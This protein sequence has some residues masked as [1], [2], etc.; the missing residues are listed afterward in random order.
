M[1]DQVQQ[2]C[3]RPRQMNI[4]PLTSSGTSAKEKK[5]QKDYSREYRQR[6]KADAETYRLFR[7]E[8]NE[9][10]REYRSRRTEEALQR[11]RELQRERQKKYRQKLKEEG[12][13]SK[14]TPR[15]RKSAE[16]TRKMEREKKRAQR[17]AM[18]HNKRT[19]IN[20][21]RRDA[22]ALKKAAKEKPTPL[23]PSTSS[24]SESAGDKSSVSSGALRTARSRFCRKFLEDL[25]TQPA[26]RAEVIS[27]GLSALSPVSK[28]AV[29]D[30]LGIM[31]PKAKRR[32]D[33]D[34][35]AAVAIKEQLKESSSKRS[36]QALKMRRLYT[37]AA[38]VKSKA[39]AKHL[40]ISRKLRKRIE[41]ANTN[42]EGWE[43]D[44]ARRKDAVPQ[45]IMDA[46]H[47]RYEE[48]SRD[49]PDARAPVVT[50]GE[51]KSRKV[52]ETSLQ[53]LYAE[54]IRQAG[55]GRV[56]S[57]ATFKRLKP[58]NILPHTSHKFRECL[59]E[60][61]VNV[62]LKLKSMN[63]KLGRY[64]DLKLQDVFEA[65]RTTL[66]PKDG[67]NYKRACLERECD[68]CGPKLI[69]AHLR[70]ALEDDNLR[71]STT[72]WYK[73]ENAQVGSFTRMSKVPK[74]STFEGLVEALQADL[75]P[76]ARHLFNARW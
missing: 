61:C 72:T 1:A 12:H 57:F 31:S 21:K 66:C 62:G 8:E 39:L 22:Y 2:R 43:E 40:G 16:E 30:K 38:I 29:H 9:R 53:S 19:A 47:S 67:S 34:T 42:R 35:M 5:T 55:P 37:R 18:S 71:C 45:N 25:P 52:L 36:L 14:R 63:S 33:L 26:V 65:S 15:T 56:V 48:S 28:R 24:T 50:G 3:L 6:I 4:D 11:N 54:Y 58:E 7:K 44:R 68:D 74:E 76:F 59:C 27:A 51:V 10:N 32:L 75:Q 17:A 69:K 49:L 41:S 70:P 23:L 13:E 46:I 64:A 73:W 20:K 60:Y